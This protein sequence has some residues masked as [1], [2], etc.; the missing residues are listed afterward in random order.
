MDLLSVC[1]VHRRVGLIGEE[2]GEDGKV[3][4]ERGRGERGKW[5]RG[6]G[7]GRRD[8][9]RRER[10]IRSLRGSSPRWRMRYL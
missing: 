3:R 2:G 10:G 6:R 4:R 7:R 8:V 9:Q 1:L 5:E